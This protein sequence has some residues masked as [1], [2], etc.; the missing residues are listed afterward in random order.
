MPSGSKAWMHAPA[1]TSRGRI[2]RLA[3]SRM[4]SVLGLKVSPK[5]AARRAAGVPAAAGGVFSAHRALPHPVAPPPRL[6]ARQPPAGLARG[7]H[8]GAAVLGKAR[9][10]KTRPGMQKLAA[11]ATVEP[12]AAGDVLDIAAHP[13]A[14][15]G[16][17]VDKGDLG[18]EKGVGRVFD[19]FGGGD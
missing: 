6:A 3:A 14:Q 19:Q 11:D 1:A 10:A 15:I 4:S 8:Q 9:A 16:D 7:A 18:G 12:D 13:F 2:S 17:L 5:T